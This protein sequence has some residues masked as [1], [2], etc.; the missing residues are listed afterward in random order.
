MGILDGRVAVITGGGRGIGRSHALRLAREGASVVVNDLG[1]A[2]DGSGPDKGPAHEVVNE[3]VAAGGKAAASV[4]D[5]A[6]WAG[7]KEIVDHAIGAFGRLDVLVNN[8]G[9]VRDGLIPSLDED[10]WDIVLDVHLKGH[11]AVLRHAAAYWKAESKAG[12]RPTA[13]VINTT[14]VSGTVMSNPG[15]ASYGAAKAAISAL[16]LVAA[17]ELAHYGVRVN[18]VA[19]AARTR[20]TLNAP[21][22]GDLLT[23]KAEEAKVTGAFDMY[24]PDNIA[25]LVAYLAAP[26]T[27]ITGRVF[28]VQ[29]GSISELV[30]WHI[31][32]TIETDGPWELDDIAN[33]VPTILSEKV[34]IS[35]I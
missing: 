13:A 33:R 29:G 2:G 11:F 9:I 22:L 6:A 32:Q 8:A 3:I 31:G 15:Q 14:S 1:V 25:P 23:T 17:E 34:P 16:T 12:R 5:V 7:A 19:P 20:M 26:H 28:L 18:A 30:N 24:S 21:G 4:S 35:L 10:Q 27:D